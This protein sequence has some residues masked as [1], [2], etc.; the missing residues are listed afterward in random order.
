MIVI[1]NSQ[2]PKPRSPKLPQGNQGQWHPGAAVARCRPSR[3]AASLTHPKETEGIYE[4]LHREKTPWCSPNKSDLLQCLQYQYYHIPGSC[5]L[6]AV[7]EEDQ[8]RI[9]VAIDLDETLVHSSFKIPRPINNADFGVPVET[10]GTTHQVC[11]LERPYMDVFPRRMGE[12]FECVLVTAS[13]AKGTDLSCVSH[14]GCYVRDLSRLGRG[15]RR[16]LTLDAWPASYSFHQENAVPVQAWFNDMADTELLNP[17]PI[18][19][20][21]SV[22][23]SFRQL[24][25]P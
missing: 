23:T 15:L 19:E 6:P 21:L 17:I 5:L 2:S 22:Y 1:L 7:T 12:L 25:C 3:Q 8:G 14:Q 24:R 4:Q 20:G 18:F 13:L 11:V 10:E 9:C 16:M